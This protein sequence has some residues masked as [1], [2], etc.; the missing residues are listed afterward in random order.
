M[1]CPKFH[2]WL[3]GQAGMETQVFR[4]SGSSRMLT[5]THPEKKSST[6]V[7]GPRVKNPRHPIPKARRGRSGSTIAG[8]LGTTDIPLESSLSF[9]P[10]RPSNWQI[11]SV[12][13]FK[14]IHLS[15][16][17]CFKS[18]VS[19]GLRSPLLPPVLPSA[20]RP[21]ATQSS[22]RGPYKKMRSCHCSS[23]VF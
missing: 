5:H 13:D 20:H 18:L 14:Y 16:H 7:R 1:T 15:P 2:S 10:L 19:P 3:G 23:P 6:S 22:R 17:P 4:L 21:Q 8:H 12:A 11:L 9:E